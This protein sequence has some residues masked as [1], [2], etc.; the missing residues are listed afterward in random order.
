MSL[1]GELRQVLAELE[2]VSHVSAARPGSSGRDTSDDI[3][4]NRPPGGID[5]GDDREPEHPQKSVEHF[6]RCLRRARTDGQLEAVLIDA[7]DA[8]A[9]WRRQPAPSGEPEYGSPQ[10]KRWVAESELAPVEI[11]RKYNVSRQYVHAI[12][13]AYRDAA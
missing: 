11:A 10:W 6:R 12:Q 5:R 3:G 7:R 1:L 2:L 4:G 8:L 9:A 13:R